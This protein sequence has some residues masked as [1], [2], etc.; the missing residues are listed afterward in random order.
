[1]NTNTVP[2][3]IVVA[4]SVVLLGLCLFLLVYT[5]PVYDQN[6]RL[7]RATRGGQNDEHE[8]EKAQTIRTY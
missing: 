6:E 7:I 5:G 8:G 3:T 1:V 4:S 2:N